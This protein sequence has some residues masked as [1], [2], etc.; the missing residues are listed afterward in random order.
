MRLHKITSALCSVLLLSSGAAL[1]NGTSKEH[2]KPH[3]KHH[4]QVEAPAPMPMAPAP[5]AEPTRYF[6]NGFYIGGQ[7]GYSHLHGKFRN[8]LFLTSGG[9]SL[10]A[11]N[12]GDSSDAFVGEVLFGYRYFM[13]PAFSLGLEVAGNWDGHD[14]SREFQTIRANV[15]NTRIVHRTKVSKRYSVVPTATFGWAFAPR[16]LVMAKVGAAITHFRLFASVGTTP[17]TFTRNFRKAGIAPSLVLEHAYTKHLSFMGTV[18][19]V[20]YPH[21]KRTLSPAEV[22]GEPR[23]NLRTKVKQLYEV[24]AKLGVT[25]RF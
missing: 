3:K 7:I 24:A 5:V 6:N 15:A 22:P 8:A 4:K 25:Y 18:S 17:V 1:A 11:A 21:L 23:S 13:R 14:V 9:D 12:G 10:M 20:A 19:F 16:W 2:Y